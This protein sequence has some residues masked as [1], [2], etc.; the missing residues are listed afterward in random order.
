LCVNPSRHRAKVVEPEKGD[1]LLQM[2]PLIGERFRRAR[3]LLGRGSILLRHL[4]ELLDYLIARCEAIA[5][6]GMPRGVP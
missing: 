3:D 1:G 2:L 6:R 5:V 4:I